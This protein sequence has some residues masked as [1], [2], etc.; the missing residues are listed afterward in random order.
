MEIMQGE[1][2]IFYGG[3]PH[4]YKTIYFLSALILCHNALDKLERKTAEPMKRKLNLWKLLE[5]LIQ[6][7]STV[8]RYYSKAEIANQ[9]FQRT[10]STFR[11]WEGPGNMQIFSLACKTAKPGDVV[12]SFQNPLEEA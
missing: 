3:R 10:E 6:I 9:V 11:N 4:S 8:K 5:E 2:V 7:K 12:P 1:N